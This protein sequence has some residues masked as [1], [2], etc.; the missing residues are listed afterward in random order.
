MNTEMEGGRE[1]QGGEEKGGVREKERGRGGKREHR[2]KDGEEN[3]KQHKLKYA[4]FSPVP[5]AKLA[6]L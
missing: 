6:F 1:R 4:V 5:E 2:W 3:S